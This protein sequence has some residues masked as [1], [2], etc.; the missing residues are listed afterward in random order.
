VS[1][2]LEEDIDS[3]RSGIARPPYWR[4]ASDHCPVFVSIKPPAS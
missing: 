4:E 3:A 2:R 1:R